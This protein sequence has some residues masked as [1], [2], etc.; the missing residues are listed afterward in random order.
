MIGVG[1]V[2]PKRPGCLAL[3]DTWLSLKVL[4]RAERERERER[5]CM[6]S[7]Q[8]VNRSGVESNRTANRRIFSPFSI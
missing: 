7:C 3:R 8:I 5:L 1:E 2:G 4:L 6:H